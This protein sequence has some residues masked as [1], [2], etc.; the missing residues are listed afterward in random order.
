ME[1]S[2]RGIHHVQLAGPPGCEE[3]ARAFYSV[4]LGMK[5]I[6]K[7]EELRKRGGVWFECPGFQVHIGIQE[8]FVPAAKAHPAFQVQGLEA[9]KERLALHGC[10]IREDAPIGTL[11]RLHTDDPFGNRLE[12]MEERL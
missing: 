9:L 2:Y 10:S 11:Y 7:P 3:Q 5:E 12:F 8:D 6:P 1:F 4:V